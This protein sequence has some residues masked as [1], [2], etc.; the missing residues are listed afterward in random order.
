MKI[1]TLVRSQQ[2]T[3]E[4]Q[5]SKHTVLFAENPTACQRFKPV[6]YVIFDVDGTLLDTVGIYG[7]VL[8]K[9]LKKFDKKLSWEFYVSILGMR[10]EETLT[11]IKEHYELPYSLQELCDETAKL[12][13]KMI[14]KAYMMEGAERLI[15]HL[16]E[17]KVNLI[18]FQNKYLSFAT[19]LFYNS[20]SNGCGNQ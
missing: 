11:K 9:V 7:D 18:G 17:N 1:P 8:N 4:N 13:I 10:R 3:F 20:D 16:Y 12:T 6:K 2:S 19:I 5:V 15:N 14:S